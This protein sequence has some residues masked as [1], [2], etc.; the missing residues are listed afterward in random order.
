LRV[1]FGRL[2]PAALPGEAVGERLLDLPDR[3]RPLTRTGQNPGRRGRESDDE[4]ESD[5]EHSKPGTAYCEAPSHGVRA[6]IHGLC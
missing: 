4:D 6:D 3:V 1:D 5:C 2:G